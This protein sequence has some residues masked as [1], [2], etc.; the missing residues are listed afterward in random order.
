MLTRR[1]LLWGASTAVALGGAGVL[2]IEDGMLPGRT[3]LNS[4]LGLDG[5]DGTVPDIEPGPTVSSSFDSA[6]RGTEVGWTIAR[7][8][9]ASGR[10]PVV[11]VL[12][13]RGG[14]HATPFR[15]T[16][17]ALDRFLAAAVAGGVPPFALA[18]VDGGEAYWHDRADGDRCGSMVLEEF[19]PLLREHD[20]DIDRIGFFG[21]SMGGFGSLHLTHTLSEARGGTRVAGVA[22]MSPALFRT[23]ADTTPGA[24]DDAADF[25]RVAVMH[26]QAT[27]DDV[28]LRVDC[29]EG[30]PFCSATREYVA[31]FDAPPA[32]GFEP[33]G[34]D[35]GYW[36]RIAPH[37]LEHLGNALVD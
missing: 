21:W 17:L 26:Q 4:A 7:P 1:S 27:F 20:L 28:P 36:R 11:V 13:G 5:P 15:G 6:A 32:G 35:V 31:G 34:H 16:H 22:V 8:P 14:N 29:G 25:E 24:Y 19:L 9:G 18:S 30:D 3:R 37:A 33:G 12:H 23:Y 2:A 10:L